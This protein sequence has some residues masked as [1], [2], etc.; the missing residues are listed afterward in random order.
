M[1]RDEGISRGD[2]SN[3][4]AKTPPPPTHKSTKQCSHSQ[5]HAGRD[6]RHVTCHVVTRSGVRPMWAVPRK[7]D[8]P[9]TSNG[10][11]ERDR[12]RF[13]LASFKLRNRAWGGASSPSSPPSFAPYN[14]GAHVADMAI[15]M[16]SWHNFSTVSDIWPL[17]T[18]ATWKLTHGSLKLHGTAG[19]E[20]IACP[21]SSAFFKN[22]K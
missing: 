20:C 21:E 17:G 18:R 11:A 16:A 9:W 7:P 12:A 5:V 6:A 8:I 10:V 2:N 3:K 4:H 13:T 1:Q 15:V 22:V 14:L 19:W